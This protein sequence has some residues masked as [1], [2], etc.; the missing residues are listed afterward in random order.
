LKSSIQDLLNRRYGAHGEDIPKLGLEDDDVI[1]RRLLE[2]IEFYKTPFPNE[3]NES[4]QYNIWYVMAPSGYAKDSRELD[5]LLHEDIPKA[6]RPATKISRENRALELISTIFDEGWQRDVKTG[7]IIWR[8]PF[9]PKVETPEEIEK[10]KA[11]SRA[12]ADAMWRR[13][14]RD[15]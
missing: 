2:L 3:K 7:K 12:M 4:P 15:S 13:G 6:K 11:Q 10:R 5:R 14:S 1:E 8:T 9:V